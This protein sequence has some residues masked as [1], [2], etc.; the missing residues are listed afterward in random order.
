MVLSDTD[1]VFS[2]IAVVVVTPG[3]CMVRTG[4]GVDTAAGAGGWAGA[5]C[6]HPLTTASTSAR[7]RQFRTFFMM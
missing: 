6:V 5:G 4:V 1:A 7:I 2:G 3:C